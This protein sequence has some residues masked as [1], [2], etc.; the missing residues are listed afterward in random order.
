M[1]NL[2]IVG[3]T[4]ACL[5]GGFV[6]TGVTHAYDLATHGRLTQQ[7]STRSR[8]PDQELLARLGI[9]ESANPFGMQYYDVSGSQVMPRSQN[10]FE[11][12]IIREAGV[13]ELTI[14]GW[15]MRGAIR[16][17]DLGEIAGLKVGGDP[18]DDP[19]GNI[20]R[21]FHHFYDPVFNRALTTTAGVLG[22]RSPEWATGT[23]NA[24]EPS[25]RSDTSRRNHFTILDAREA[26]YRAL[27]GRNQSGTVV[28]PTVEERNSYW[29]TTF[30]AL[31]DVIHLVQDAA[32]PQHA[33]NDPHSGVPG[34]G[35]K[36]VYEA[37]TDARATGAVSFRIDNTKVIPQ[38]LD[39][40]SY[41]IP[42][43][44]RYGDFFSTRT[45]TS[46]KGI[47][48]YSN[49]G[50]F[51]A[52]TNLGSNPY[53]LPVNDSSRYTPESTAIA[54]LFPSQPFAKMNFLRGD[55]T[56]TQVPG[57]DNVRL[58]TESVW[59]LFLGTVRTYSLN[60]F[61]Y[62]DM[63]GLLIPRAAAYSAGLIDYFF[64]GRLLAID[65]EFTD[66]GVSFKIR[67][68]IDVAAVPEWGNEVLYGSGSAMVLAYEYA[69]DGQKTVAS[70]VPQP[71]LEDIEPGA[72]STRIYTF[73][74][75]GLPQ[76]ARKVK[77]RLVF[78]GRLGQERDSVAVGVVEPV[79]GFL[80]SP[81]YLPS[82]GIYGSRA[83]YRV[84]GE[85]KLDDE[86]GKVAGNIDWKGW[87]VNGRPS[88]VLTW[89]GPSGRYFGNGSF[90]RQ[91][92]QAGEVYSVAPAPVYGAA[93]NKSEGKEWIV[94]IC[95]P[96]RLEEIVYR[97]PN[98]KNSSPA[99]FDPILSP[100]GWQE[101]GRFAPPADTLQLM[102]WFFNASGTE[103][104][105]LRPIL[106]D[107]DET[108]MKTIRR[109]ITI[110]GAVATIADMENHG[111]I[112]T[113]DYFEL[114]RDCELY[115]ERTQQISGSYIVAV[116]YEGDREVI[117]TWHGSG[118][119]RRVSLVRMF[120]SQ[121]SVKRN[122]S[123]R[124]VCDAMEFQVSVDRREESR[125]LEVPG[126]EGSP[127][128]FETLSSERLIAGAAYIDIRSGL[129]AYST[130][131]TRSNVD[132]T[133]TSNLGCDSYGPSVAQVG[134]GVEVVGEQAIL[135]FERSQQTTYSATT[136]KRWSDGL[137]SHSWW[138]CQTA[139][140]D[141]TTSQTRHYPSLWDFR[142]IKVG[143][144][145][146]YDTNGNFL[147]SHDDRNSY[148]FNFLTGGD[149]GSLIPG[150]GASAKYSPAR[151]LK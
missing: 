35:H 129:A 59:D 66:A 44:T 63:A 94:A 30:R 46:G 116:D 34:F 118:Q 108:G 121:L 22:S 27:T 73:A 132:M 85:W 113:S 49:R 25:P 78:R 43:F 81:N 120:S 100:D 65:P 140:H 89:N 23:V 16:E 42:R 68:G 5:I 39:Y 36:S 148:S 24:F 117:C 33:R 130:Q 6:T 74:I 97:R 86:T 32:Q 106:P 64:R 104:Q 127:S 134:V 144:S 131:R 82:D 115:I 72:T 52:G 133:A 60:R 110:S 77:Y 107:A 54:G 69:V 51:T 99:L 11:N 45:G 98:T 61:N 119:A 149:L 40:G 102:P 123:D 18:H 28:A 151:V 126:C 47:A 12:K 4:V 41:P 13:G 125:F 124:I 101:V 37:Y 20:F 83:I 141:I 90:E 71:L 96:D 150:G 9:T 50:F 103:A 139:T 38:A 105:T 145:Y 92:Y 17:D 15:L 70:T 87:Y 138:T 95:S 2:L 114:R 21:V 84:N 88:K 79:S 80:V 3:L 146:V 137:T 29:A 91:I 26:M 19:Y 62:D 93:L 143:G 112:T 135:E 76:Y 57:A 7:A 14:V 67:N 1:S 111:G 31:G 56:D 142:Y 147:I 75:T 109:R 128:G 8:L 10:A 136:S 55:V 53:S 58:T 122:L 48:D